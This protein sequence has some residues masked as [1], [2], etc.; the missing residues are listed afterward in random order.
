[1]CVARLTVHGNQHP[2]G[3]AGP[4]PRAS[5]PAAVVLHAAAR[6][7][8]LPPH[9]LA[10]IAGQR[11]LRG[12]DRGVHDRHE[13]VGHGL[14]REAVGRGGVGLHDAAAARD[15]V[16]LCVWVG[17]G[18]VRAC[19]LVV[20]AHACGGVCV[21]VWWRV[22]AGSGAVNGVAASRARP[23]GAGIGSASESGDA[24]RASHPRATHTQTHTHTDRNTHAHTRAHTHTHTHLHVV[25]A[26]AAGAVPR[27]HDQVHA[28]ARAHVARARLCRGRAGGVCG[29]QRAGVVVLIA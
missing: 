10:H 1:M 9:V 29:A 23:S 2:K 20:C 4:T 8:H 17:V 26:Q 12:G 15:L 22:G 28:L 11:R 25:L 27:L 18:C 16:W 14:R 21:C 7:V 6:D 5:A 19:V 24:R 13:V 3:A